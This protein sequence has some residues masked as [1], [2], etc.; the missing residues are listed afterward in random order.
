[1]I[2]LFDNGIKFISISRTTET[3]KTG[4]NMRIAVASRDGHRVAGH[5]GKC[6]D[7]I[8]FDAQPAPAGEQLQVTQHAL[9]N[10]PKELVFHHYRDEAPH[11]LSD[12]DAVIGASAGDSFVE[13]MAQRGI[14]VVLTAETDPATAVADFIRQQVVPPKPR[15]IGG[16]I[17]KIRDAMSK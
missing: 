3:L 1:L 2:Q 14:Q 5:I 13:K 10:L 12:C 9:V 11:P 16:L 7:W 6:R 15:P 17:C 4:V 8:V